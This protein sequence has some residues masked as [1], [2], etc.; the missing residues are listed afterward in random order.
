HAG[1]H[2][3]RLA[4]EPSERAHGLCIYG[5]ERAPMRIVTAAPTSR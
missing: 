3:V 2:V 4:V 1:R 5:D